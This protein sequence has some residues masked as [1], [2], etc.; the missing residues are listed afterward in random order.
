MGRSLVPLHYATE[1]GYSDA[2][3]ALLIAGADVTARSRNG[4]A[5]LRACVPAR[6]WTR[7]LRAARW[8]W[9]AAV[10]VRAWIALLVCMMEGAVLVCARVYL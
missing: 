3:V 2:I 5:V 4:Y 8:R 6:V 10:R 1:S 9:P 7:S